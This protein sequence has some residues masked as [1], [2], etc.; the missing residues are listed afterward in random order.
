MELVLPFPLLYTVSGDQ[1][2][3]ISPEQLNVC[4]ILPAVLWGLYRTSYFPPSSPPFPISLPSPSPHFM[5][6]EAFCAHA[7]SSFRPRQTRI[8][9]LQI[10]C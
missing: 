1:M 3:F 9:V 5:T 8:L 4:A 10:F 7:L 2:C 6:S